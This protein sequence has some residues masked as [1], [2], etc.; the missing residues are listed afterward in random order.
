MKAVSSPTKM[1]LVEVGHS[2]V[3]A[4]DFGRATL[5][6]LARLRWGL[7]AAGILLLVVA[8]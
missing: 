4:P 6:R 1:E 5:R 8:T 7:A 3:D 2:R